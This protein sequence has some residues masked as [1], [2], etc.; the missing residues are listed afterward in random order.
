[1]SESNCGAP[2]RL[3]GTLPWLSEERLADLSALEGTRGLT[4]ADTSWRSRLL[5]LRGAV[6]VRG[7]VRRSFAGCSAGRRAHR[8]GRRR[9]SLARRSALSRLTCR[10]HSSRWASQPSG[11]A[12][13]SKRTRCM[14]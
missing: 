4:S 1:M 2:D 10:G 5:D 3:L 12:A 11:K 6:A 14:S 13:S 7:T 9:R 8:P